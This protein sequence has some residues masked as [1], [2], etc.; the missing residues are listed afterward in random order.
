MRQH[1]TDLVGGSLPV[2]ERNRRGEMREGK[3]RNHTVG[4]NWGET[5]YPDGALKGGG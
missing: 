1:P 4:K 3:V 5:L 2:G